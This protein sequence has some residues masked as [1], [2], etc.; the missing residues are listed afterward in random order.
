M[1]YIIYAGVVIGAI[2]FVWS[3]FIG[4]IQEKDRS[5]TDPDV[6]DLPI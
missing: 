6:N 1:N 3:G 2:L 5:D 4:G